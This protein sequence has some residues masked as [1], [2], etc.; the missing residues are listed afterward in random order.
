MNAFR[1]RRFGQDKWETSSG[2]WVYVFGVSK[3]RLLG[4]CDPDHNQDHVRKAVLS[5]T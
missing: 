5:F 2:R 1:T 3:H 4:S